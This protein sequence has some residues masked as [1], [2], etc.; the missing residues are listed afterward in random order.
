MTSPRVLV[1]AFLVLSGV[2]ARMHLLAQ[3]CDSIASPGAQPQPIHGC[4]PISRTPHVVRWYEALAVAATVPAAF[5]VDQPLQR[6]VQRNRGAASNDIASVFRRLGQPEVYATVSLGTLAAGLIL[7][8]PGVTRAGGRLIASVV[9]SAAASE[10]IKRLA[11]RARPDSGL[12][13]FHFDPF[14]GSG[15]FPSGHATCVFAL[16]TSAAD[17]LHN[18]WAT[19]GLYTIATGTAFSRI[20]DDRHWFSDTVLGAA[21]GITS[22]KLMDGHWQIFGIKSPHFLVGPSGSGFTV[23][24]R[25]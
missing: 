1:C 11:G 24:L 7:G 13:A 16:A 21:L 17:H 4:R 12:G 19:I 9:V 5:L 18:T 3:Q 6:F 14:G 8:K 10:S 15:S 22:A 23:S 2:P 25:F 20:N